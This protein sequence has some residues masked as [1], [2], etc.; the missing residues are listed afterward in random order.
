MSATFSFP[1]TFPYTISFRAFLSWIQSRAKRSRGRHI[2]FQTWPMEMSFWP[3]SKRNSSCRGR[4]SE[5]QCTISTSQDSRCCSHCGDASSS[6]LT[7]PIE[8]LILL[9]LSRSGKAGVLRGVEGTFA[10]HV[11][12]TCM[13]VRVLKQMLGKLFCENKRS[14]HG[15]LNQNGCGANW[16]GS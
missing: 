15:S 2:A 4:L 10:G 8:E 13:A 3:L 9:G 7:T 12:G 6:E 16:V 5:F 1:S 14:L 11:A